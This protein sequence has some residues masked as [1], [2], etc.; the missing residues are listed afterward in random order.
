VLR[1]DKSHIGVNLVLESCGITMLVLLAEG[2]LGT[3][4]P[5][6]HQTSHGQDNAEF[7]FSAHHASVGFSSF[8]ERV[9]FDH[10]ANAG[11]FAK[12][13]VSSESVGIP[14]GQPWIRFLPII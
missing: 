4:T 2:L 7:C 6:C 5:F 1:L 3:T 10:W 9:L 12:R 14:V 11:H 8:R 13:S